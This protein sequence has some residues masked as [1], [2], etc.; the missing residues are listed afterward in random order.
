MPRLAASLRLD[1]R[2]GLSMLPRRRLAGITLAAA[3]VLLLW[4][5]PASAG[6]RARDPSRLWAEYPIGTEPLQ[7][8]AAK[9]KADPPARARTRTPA[10]A[11][12]AAL[13]PDPAATWLWLLLAPAGALAVL[14]VAVFARARARRRPITHPQRGEA[15]SE[16][17][18]FVPVDESY[19]LVAAKGEPPDVGTWL[20]RNLSREHVFL[21]QKVGPSPLPNDSRRCAY[22]ER[23]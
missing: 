23:W 9:P 2:F 3:T 10:A 1:G 5:A 8:T 17:L 18:L 20:N 4:S 13:R 14:T 19:V 15:G 7:T 11:E 6:E 12:P 21:V 16:H 22:L